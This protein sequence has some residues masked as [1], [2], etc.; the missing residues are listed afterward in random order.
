MPAMCGMWDAG[1]RGDPTGNICERG[2][3]S[4][5]QS[6]IRPDREEGLSR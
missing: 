5:Q 1:V 6:P 3:Q 2:L 4:C